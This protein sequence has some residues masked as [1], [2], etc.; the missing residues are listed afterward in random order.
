MSTFT[1]SRAADADIRNIARYTQ[2]TWGRDQRR[3]YLDGLNQKF[4]IL[5]AMPEMAAERRDFHPPVRI[6]HY[7][8]HLIVYVIADEG[9][10]IMRV[11]H[12]NMNVTAQMSG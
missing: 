3:R 11:L 5:A 1:V 2:D 7:E 10:L 9:I 4:D 12:Q 6:H 8:K